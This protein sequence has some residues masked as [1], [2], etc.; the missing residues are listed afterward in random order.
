M[1]LNIGCTLHGMWN[2]YDQGTKSYVNSQNKRKELKLVFFFNEMGHQTQPA[3]FSL[4]QEMYSLPKRTGKNLNISSLD[5][6]KI[7]EKSSFDLTWYF[8][9]DIAQRIQYQ[10]SVNFT[11]KIH[12]YKMGFGYTKATLTACL[13]HKKL[14]NIYSYIDCFVII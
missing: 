4:V 12:I 6:G 3:R 1:Q 2:V 10:K 11:L 5:S 9:D 8:F 7:G 14:D 13:V